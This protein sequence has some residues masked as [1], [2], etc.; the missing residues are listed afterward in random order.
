MGRVWAGIWTLIFIYLTV[1]GGLA[2]GLISFLAALAFM[3]L[4]A[5]FG[6]KAMDL[7]IVLAM[8]S[9]LFAPL[10]G[11]CMNFVPEDV[12]SRI[13]N[14]WGHRVEMWGYVAERIAEKP[15][16]GHG[17]DA[18]RT[19]DATYSGM[20]INGQAIEMP[21]VSLHPHNAG[22]HIWAET[23]AVGAVLAAV[24]LALI[25][26]AGIE[27]TTQKPEL[28]IPF[29]GFAAAAI[30]ICT[31]TFGVWQD[32]WWASLIMAGSIRH[33]VPRKP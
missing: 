14:S 28:A 7:L 4:T 24:T 27:A 31:V 29:A 23:G 17:F 20:Q 33:L 15:I 13:S 2:I 5:R 6:F 16:I 30:T 19:F 8:T 18:S 22:L 21:I 12:K 9:I 10:I 11:Y 1:K 3:A 26:R 25:G 32:W